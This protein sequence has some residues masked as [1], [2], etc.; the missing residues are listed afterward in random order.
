MSSYRSR[1]SEPAY[2]SKRRAPARAPS[3]APAKRSKRR[4][5]YIPKKALRSIGA[6]LPV[7]GGLIGGAIGGMAG[8]IGAVPG[9]ALGT[10]L[11]SVGQSMLSGFG[12]YFVNENVFLRGSPPI[13]RNNSAG[14]TVIS[15]REFIG[16]VHSSPIAN[17]FDLN[18]HKIVPTAE[19]SFPWL[20]QI[21]GNYQEWSP[22]GIVYEYRSV[23]ADA[24]N[25]VNTSLGTV[26]LST[27]YNSALPNFGSEAEMLNSEFSSSVKPSENVMHMIECKRSASVLGNL[28]TKTTAD[29]DV[30]FS[31]LGNFQIATTG[32]QGTDVLCGQLWVTYQISLNKPKL[33]DILNLDNLISW[34]QAQAPTNDN[35]LGISRVLMANSNMAIIAPTGTHIVFPLSPVNKTY[36]VT[37][38]WSGTPVA[39]AAYPSTS[40]LG[41]A[42][43]HPNIFLESTGLVDSARGLSGVTSGFLLLDQLV[44]V[45]AGSDNARLFFNTDGRVPTAGVCD[46]K[47]M[48]ISNDFTQTTDTIA[49]LP[50]Q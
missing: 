37:V 44:N 46:I 13:I 50:S 1:Y 20:S 39:S 7:A 2:R 31:Q 36:M 17:T 29:E 48:E 47:I 38:Y 10:A 11:G 9:G 25:S 35:P 41:G 28:Y 30:R 19:S 45:I 16:N 33:N 23:S 3:R 24:L 18:S 42:S 21:A 49:F 43:N 6:G 12:D 8:G 40:Y 26:M 34:V 5:T 15:F 32:F 14:G 22:E 4:T 27:N